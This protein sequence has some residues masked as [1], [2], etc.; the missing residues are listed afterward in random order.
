MGQ[1][2][3]TREE[4]RECA[5]NVGGIRRKILE[6]RAVNNAVGD[7]PRF[8]GVVVDLDALKLRHA[9]EEVVG[10]GRELVVAENEDLEGAQPV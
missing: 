6:G 7:L 10:D 9:G 2:G 4:I 3:K 5:D 1:R 8:E